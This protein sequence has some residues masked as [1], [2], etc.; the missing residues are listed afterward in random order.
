M[1]SSA[2]DRMLITAQGWAQAAAAALEKTHKR[3]PLPAERCAPRP[4]GKTGVKMNTRNAFTLRLAAVASAIGMLVWGPASLANHPNC[5]NTN[6]PFSPNVSP[7]TQSAFSEGTVVP[8]AVTVGGNI[9]SH[10]FTCVWSSSTGPFFSN[11]NICNPTWTAPSVTGPGTF[12]YELSVKVT[13]VACPTRNPT[14]QTVINVTDTNQ[15]P[16]ANTG[17]DANVLEGQ[18]VVLDG[19]ASS[20]PEGGQLTYNWSQIE[21]TT[22]QLKNATGNSNYNGGAVA[23]FIAPNHPTSTAGETLKFQLSVKDPP[24]AI[25][26]G[27]KIVNVLWANDPPDANLANCQAPRIV[28]EGE[29]V[30]INGSASADFDDGIAS[31]SWTQ[32]NGPPNINVGAVT[33]HTLQFTAPQLVYPQNGKLEF[34]LTVTDQAGMSSSET[35]KVNIQDATAPVIT[36][37]ADITAEAT[38]ASGA[39]VTYAVTAEDAHDGPVAPDLTCTRASGSLFPIGTT[40][41]KCTAT[42]QAGNSSDATFKVTVEDTT[43]PT[44]SGMPGNI[45]AEATGPNGAVVSWTAPTASDIVDGVVAVNCTPASG[46]TFAIGTHTVNCTATDLHT[47]QSSASFTITVRDTTPPTISGMPANITL[48]GNTLGGANVTWPAPSASDIVDG[49]VTVGCVPASGSLFGLGTTTVS[50]TAKDAAN[51]PASASFTVTVVDTTPPDTT[52]TSNPPNPTNNFS[53]TFGFTGS[54]I[55]TAAGSLTFECQLDGGGFSSCSSTTTYNGLLSGSHTFQVRARDQAGNTDPTPASYTWIVN[56]PPENVV[57]TPTSATINEGGSV[58]LGGSFADPNDNGAHTVTIDWG[59]GSSPTVLSLA[60]GTFTFTASHQYLDDSPPGGYPVTVTVRDSGGLEGSG[61]TAV[62]VLNLPPVTTTLAGP[63]GPLAKPG[64]TTI[65]ANFTDAGVKDTHSCTFGW[66]D[67]TPNTTSPATE[68]NGSGYC[69]QT[70]TFT[71]AGVYAV[72]ITVTD[73]DTGAATTTYQFVV[74]YDPSAGFVTGG[75]WINSPAGAYMAD[76]SLT[77][78]ANFGFVSRY[79]RGQ[80]V[81]SGETEFQFHAAGFKFKSTSYDWLVISGPKA[82]YKG[83][84]TANGVD[85][86]AFLLTA[87]DG[88]APGGGGVDKF[89]IK[90]WHKET[91]TLVY[92]NVVGAS[93]DIDAANPQ[94]L[95]GGSITIHSR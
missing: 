73:D 87:T 68:A 9:A 36:V 35:C 12:P 80:S 39:Q 82:Q 78:K 18:T 81:P 55:V 74:V 94:A 52:I 71:A 47:N 28:D 95:G 16:I 17:G 86:Y 27:T 72:G 62:G 13:S 3:T 25:G 31:Y 24:G 83:L 69:E 59:D 85:G 60:G 51:N 93:D 41:V 22:V 11:P 75:G 43:P 57:A 53:A 48:E 77:G 63:G 33:G 66:D 70:H 89:R 50:C 6:L 32:A 42:D 49:S 40:T 38:S 90:I 10:G 61:V 23:T 88:Q 58:Q 7:A 21:G 56:A 34:T 26:L 8:L 45:T 37:P 5:T 30:T 44:I 84:G 19:S 46:G 91:G 1:K 76:Q 64:T 29:L 20:D 54:D 65:R 2:R 92:D 14:V 79:Q 4:G 15:T 67:A